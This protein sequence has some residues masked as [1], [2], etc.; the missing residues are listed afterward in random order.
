MVWTNEKALDPSKPLY[1][2]QGRRRIKIYIYKWESNKSKR[3]TPHKYGILLVLFTVEKLIFPRLECLQINNEDCETMKVD[4]EI[5]KH[6]ALRTWLV[7]ARCRY[8]VSSWLKLKFMEKL[9]TNLFRWVD[10]SCCVIPYAFSELRRCM[11]TMG[12]WSSVGLS[13][14][15]FCHTIAKGLF[16][17]VVLSFAFVF[18]K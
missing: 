12:Y 16:I 9:R 1:Q 17:L 5:R 2:I 8:A 10:D 13:F 18:G 6:N 3:S 11:L 14:L 4:S 15:P 7:L